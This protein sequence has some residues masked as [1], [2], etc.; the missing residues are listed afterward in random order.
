MDDVVA[1]VAGLKIRRLKL[2]FGLLYV[3]GESSLG[4]ASIEE[5]AA[6][7]VEFRRRMDSDMLTNPVQAP[8]AEDRTECAY[9]VF[10]GTMPLGGRM[11]FYTFEDAWDLAQA[12]FRSHPRT[13]LRIMRVVQTFG[14]LQRGSGQ[15]QGRHRRHLPA[16]ERLESGRQESAGRLE[17][18]REPRRGSGQN[19]HDPHLDGTDGFETAGHCSGDP[20]AP[21]ELR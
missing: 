14:E 15:H 17:A 16:G 13:V 18:S 20:G 6:F 12:Y 21:G 19:G 1:T 9:A 4:Y 5:A 7:A 2:P 10:R 8:S 3:V 11:D